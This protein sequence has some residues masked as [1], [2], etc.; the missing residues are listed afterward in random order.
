[1][2]TPLYSNI[3]I[4]KL[5]RYQAFMMDFPFIGTNIK[6]RKSLTNQL[7]L[8]DKF[9]FEAWREFSNINFIFG[10]SEK[11]AEANAWPNNHFL[12]EDSID[13]LFYP[14]D[15]GMEIAAICAEWETKNGRPLELGKNIPYKSL[16]KI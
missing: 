9:P 2:A 16:F 7:K 12:P 13:L 11:I 3:D 14:Y 5:T 15:D 6:I 8:R 10:F 4:T 1:M